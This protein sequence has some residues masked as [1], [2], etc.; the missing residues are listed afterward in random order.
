MGVSGAGITRPPNLPLGRHPLL[1][2]RNASP[3]KLLTGK[4]QMRTLWLDQIDAIRST[5]DTV[6]QTEWSRRDIEH[7]FGIKKEAARQLMHTIAFAAGVKQEHSAC[8]FVTTENIKALLTRLP[9][10]PPGACKNARTALKVAAEQII[11]SLKPAPPINQAAKFRSSPARTL[12]TVPL[13]QMDPILIA[14]LIE[15]AKGKGVSVADYATSVLRAH[16]Q[17]FAKGTGAKSKKE[18]DLTAIPN[19]F[20]DSDR[21]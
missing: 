2:A 3:I 18:P 19:L 11:R 12:D 16:A 5:I 20:G 13:V 21:H 6:N 17:T 14:V 15:A 9:D 10:I 4:K 8:P 7:L 1:V